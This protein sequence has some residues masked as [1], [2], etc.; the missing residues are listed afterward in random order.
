MTTPRKFVDWPCPVAVGDVRNE[1]ALVFDAGREARLL[2]IP[3]LF[4]VANKLRHLAVAVLERLDAAGID[5]FLPDLPGCNESLAPLAQQTLGGWRAGAAAAAQHFGATAVL[6]MRGGALLRPAGLPG[7]DYAPQDGAKIL[8][9]LVRARIIASREA[10]NEESRDEIEAQGRTE[11]VTLSGWQ[12]G[13]DMFTALETAVPSA[14]EVGVT[15]IDQ[16]TIDGRPLW[17]RAEPDH[18]PAQA[19]ALAAVIA[20]AMRQPR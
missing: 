10:G 11:G 16:E 9:G 3:P 14:R 6:T 5:G 1:A 7:W 12:I 4:E 20:I 18:A 8:R 13:P 15:L 17:L 19:D 2:I